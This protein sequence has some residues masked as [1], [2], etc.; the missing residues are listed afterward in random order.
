MTNAQLLRAYKENN[1]ITIKKEYSG[2]YIATVEGKYYRIESLKNQGIE[3][4]EWIVNTLEGD[5]VTHSSSL[6]EGQIDLVN[7]YA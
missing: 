1:M 6:T 4:N 3:S 7:L 2:S 5:Y